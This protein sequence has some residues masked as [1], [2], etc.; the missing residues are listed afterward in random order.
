MDSSYGLWS[1]LFF[2]IL[3]GF[4]SG[5]ETA[6]FSLSKIQLSRLE[7]DNS[8]RSRRILRLLSRPRQLLITILLGNTIVNIMASIVAA[9]YTYQLGIEL[10]LSDSGMRILLGAEVVI[11]TLLLLVFGEVTPKLFAYARAEALAGF[12]G[13]ILETMR[14]SLWPLI[15]ILE[16]ISLIFSKKHA[17]SQP[18]EQQITSEDLRNIVNSKSVHH[19]LEEDEKKMIASIFRLPSTKAKEIMIPRVD[20]IGIDIADGMDVLK[21]EILSSGHSRIP[22]YRNSIDNIIGFVYA[23][24]IILNEGSKRLEQLIRKPVF[25]PEN[26]KV[27]NLLNQFRA[28]KVHIAIVVDEYGGTSG[29]ISLEDILEEMFG[30]IMDEHDNEMPKISRVSDTEFLLSGMI[31]IAELNQEFDLEIEEEEFDNLA[32]FLLAAFKRVPAKNEKYTHNNRAVFTV[33]NIKKNRINYVIMNLLSP[34]GE[35]I[36]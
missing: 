2:F 32:G 30:E 23:K 18:G 3:S 34:P 36:D 25:V 29:L 14:I 27:Q 35:Y 17:A 19:P 28:S 24:D 7:K 15:K 1:M 16:L 13:F 20:I 6:F 11:M 33:S 22:V 4:F 21:Q 9:A 10:G 8:S 31:T 26:M 5:S 12:S